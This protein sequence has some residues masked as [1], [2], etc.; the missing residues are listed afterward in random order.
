MLRVRNKKVILE[1]LQGEVVFEKLVVAENLDQDDLT[2][3]IVSQARSM[4]VLIETIPRSKMEKR[5]TG[6]SH[7]AIIGF[8]KS[9]RTVSI[10]DLFDNLYGQ[11]KEPFFLLLNKVDFPNNLGVMIRAAF[12]A[13][14]NG[15][16][17]QSLTEEFFNEDVVHF[18]MGTIVRIPLIKMSIFEALK[19][20]KKNNI[21]TFALQ[22]GGRVYFEEDL[23]GPVAFVLGAEK[24]GVS[25][26]V[27]SRC[28]K[29][30]SIPMSSGID[31]LNVSSAASIVL[32]EK[33]RRETLRIKK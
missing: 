27:S 9:P 5:R 2:R 17:F 32:Y 12:A 7:E 4:N 3:K 16:I 25:D 24:Q 8:L 13:G 29:K 11:G 1:L 14:I 28:D 21:K 30:L 15:V 10:K 20:L 19:E 33:V 6:Q 18:S 22:M 23:S 31:S 26:T